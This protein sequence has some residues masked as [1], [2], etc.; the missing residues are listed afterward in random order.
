[1]SVIS[2]LYKNGVAS[3]APPSSIVNIKYVICNECIMLLKVYKNSF[4]YLCVNLCSSLV[5]YIYFGI[6]VYTYNWCMYV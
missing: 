3:P 5:K 1:M 4:D 2:E 6:I